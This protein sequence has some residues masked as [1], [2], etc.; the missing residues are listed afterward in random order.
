MSFLDV[1]HE[2]DNGIASRPR[3]QTNKTQSTNLSLK[4]YMLVFNRQLF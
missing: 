3:T 2:F 1:A 4:Y